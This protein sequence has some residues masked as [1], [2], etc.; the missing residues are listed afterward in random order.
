M[1]GGSESVVL[2]EGPD[3][4]AFL[5][6]WLRHLGC[7]ERKRPRQ[8][9]DPFGNGVRPPDFALYGTGGEFI[10]VRPCQGQNNL[11]RQV[12]QRLEGAR[13]KPLN[14]LVVCFDADTLRTGET[15]TTDPLGPHRDW[16]RTT[17]GKLDGAVDRDDP[18]RARLHV[19]S[20]ETRV[21]L[22]VWHVDDQPHEALPDKQTLE[23]LVCASLASAYPDHAEQV[24][25]WLDARPGS[26]S[27]TAKAWAWSWMAGW[28]AD[29][30]CERFYEAIWRDESLV[31][32]LEARLRALGAWER[33]AGLVR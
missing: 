29:A 33:L 2:C 26:P 13:T 21:E 12:L 7:D 25:A 3:D 11:K 31:R 9:Q 14:G 1:S 16:L 10:R 18:D 4:R 5:R 17:A 22:V 15:A 24:A 30:G 32:E 28:F 6:G 20:D 23:R 19:G 8:A 27:T